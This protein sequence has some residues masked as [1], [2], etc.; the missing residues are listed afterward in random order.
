VNADSFIWW[1]WVDRHLGEIRTATYEHLRLT[2]IAVGLGFVLSLA[3]ALLSLRW[4]AARA[5]VTG[6]AGLLYTI[7]SLALF[8]V[9]VTITG[10][11]TLTA[12]IGLV[13]YTLLILVRNIIEGIE[14]VPAAVREAAEGMGLNPLRRL[15]AVDLRLATPAIVAGLRIATVTTVGLVTVTGLIGMGG[16]GSFIDEGLKRSFSTEI[17]VGAG[18]SVVMA[19]ALDSVLVGIQR[20]L[21]P[22]QR[23]SRHRTN[24]WYELPKPIA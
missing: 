8:A 10:F 13:G 15:V 3:L 23:S 21:T 9:L 24:L 19:M 20:V 7:P 6:L 16:Y 14:G 18:L 1:D 4:R 22:W 2:V 11:S 12:E 5:I 17:V